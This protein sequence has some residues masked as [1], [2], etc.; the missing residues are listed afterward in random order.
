MA[1]RARVDLTPNSCFLSKP[2]EREPCGF[3]LGLF[4]CPSCRRGHRLAADHHVDV[5]N[6]AMVGTLLSGYAVIRQR[7]AE[8]LQPF[9][10]RR[11]EV[12]TV[13]VWPL[14]VFDRVVEFPSQER[15]R[16][17]ETA[18]EVN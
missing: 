7:S 15:S 11:F 5:K 6:L 9:L 12:L 10:Q 14:P 17:F 4:F 8:R 3:L 2:I 18:V 13:E 1:K 16:C